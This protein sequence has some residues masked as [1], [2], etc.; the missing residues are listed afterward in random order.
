MSC[1]RTANSR[2]G[3]YIFCHVRD[4]DRLH[5][6][7]HHAILTMPFRGHKTRRNPVKIVKKQVFGLGC[8]DFYLHKAKGVALRPE[9]VGRL[10]CF[11]GSFPVNA[12]YRSRD[13]CSVMDRGEAP[14]AMHRTKRQIPSSRPEVVGGG[15]MLHRTVT[16]PVLVGVALRTQSVAGG[17]T[18]DS[19]ITVR[20]SSGL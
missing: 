14:I 11:P 17:I 18:G 13:S 10:I 5:A 15:P 12:R 3:L 9:G 4:K 2:L 7:R 16:T 8:G 1:S 19:L 20:R 6:S